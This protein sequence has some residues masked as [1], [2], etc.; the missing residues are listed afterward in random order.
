MVFFRNL[1]IRSKLLGSFTLIFILATLLGGTAI[2]F[3][4]KKTIEANIE[5][6]L[7]N[8][9]ETILNMVKTA[10]GTSIK[11]HL[12]A[13]SEK[14]KQIIEAIYKDYQS[15][16]MTEEAAK[17]LSTKILMSQTI[18]KTGYLYCVKSDGIV[19][20]HPRE[21]VVGLNHL[22]VPFVR[23]QIRVK[24]GYLEYNWKNPEDDHARAKAL[25][26]SYFE[27]WDWIISASSY[28]EEFKELVNVSDFRDSILALSFGKTGYAYVL[29][30]KGNLIVHPSLSGNY[31]N[32]QAEDGFLFVQEIC[33]LKNGKL[34]YSWKNPGET[35]FRDKIILFN[36][37]PKYDWIVACSSYLDEMYAPLKTIRNIILLTVC[38]IMVL[39]FILSLLITGSVLKPLRHLMNRMSLGAAGDLSVRMPVASKDE[40]G[41]LAGFF[42]TFMET[43]ERYNANLTA[44]IKV[45]K[46][47]ESALRLSEE[48]FSK[49]F[50][51]SPSGMFIAS[52]NDGRVLNVN[53][54]FLQFTGATQ[55]NLLG[56]ELAALNFF[57]NRADAPKLIKRMVNKRHLKNMEI[58]FQKVS[59]EKRT[60]LLSAEIVDLWGEPCI[61][62]AMEDLTEAKQLEREILTISEQERQKIAMDLHDDICPELIGIEVLTKILMEK[63]EEKAI[64]EAS[65]AFK[66]RQLILDTIAK[67]RQV[68]RGLSPINLAE[69]GF[70]LSLE[71]LAE[72]IQ[73]VFGIQCV[74]TYSGGHPIKEKSLATDIY[75]IAHEAVHN[76]ARHSNA[77]KISVNLTITPKKITLDVK[78]NGTGI[79]LSRN[80]HGLGLKIMKYRAHRI[81]AFLNIVPRKNG[82]TLVQLNIET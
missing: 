47:I 69:L 21:G 70:D 44:E 57:Q 56:K 10:A 48:M 15:G 54:S 25:Y 11:N 74:F 5:S 49:A 58:K 59:G 30:G 68:S 63:L 50:Q 79:D 4:A 9:T 62:A 34:I 51:C 1:R 75:Y 27:P 66:I 80:T 37:I 24:D 60:G 55:K 18:G 29:D 82:G 13:V 16:K 12:R 28:R 23:E 61:L 3:Q 39:M 46:Q 17:A 22:K 33:R 8:S 2:Y 32:A 19:P 31:M 7:K 73:E 35:E 72:Y 78:D 43:L 40:I 77:N 81:G 41:Q 36:Y 26:M 76:A 64:D 20:I 53:D 65:E 71:E 6:E 67:T 42:N 38:G 45:Q 52:L 14:N